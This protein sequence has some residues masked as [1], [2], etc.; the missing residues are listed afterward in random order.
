MGESGCGKTTLG[1][2][3]L[4]LLK[5]TGGEVAFTFSDS[6]RQNLLALG[7]KDLRKAQ[8]ELQVIFQD[9]YPSLNPSATIYKTMAK[10]LRIHGFSDIRERIAALLEAVNLEPDYMYRYPHEFSG[11]QRQRIGVAMA[12]SVEPRLVICDEP[13]SALD[14]SIQAQVLELLSDLQKK[15]G[16]T[17]LFI[18]HD[19]SVVEY[20]SDRIAVMY[21]DWVVECT[22]A[23]KLY[24][25][26]R[27]A[28][29]IHAAVTRKKFVK[30][31]LRA[32]C[33]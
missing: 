4:Q 26:C 30:G 11:G 33:P 17:Y 2:C 1:K 15:M 6:S 24:R 3:I 18:A 20:I 8:K 23:E 16:L 28:I 22:P 32:S 21:L 13:V 12:L 27:D 10:P 14:V 5:S 7:K 29:S 31:K 9:P 19:I 25:E